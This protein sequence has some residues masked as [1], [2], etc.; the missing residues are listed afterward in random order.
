VAGPHELKLIPDLLREQAVY[1]LRYAMFGTFIVAIAVS[2]VASL[3]G[4]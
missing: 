3:L 4:R 1:A 2:S